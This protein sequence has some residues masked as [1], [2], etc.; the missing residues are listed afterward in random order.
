MEMDLIRFIVSMGEDLLLDS[1]SDSSDISVYYDSEYD[2]EYEY[3]FYNYLNDGEDDSN[4]FNNWYY[5][6]SNDISKGHIAP[7]EVI[8]DALIPLSLNENRIF[9]N[10]FLC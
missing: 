10:I 1:D 8:S 3:A 9:Y 7:A 2:S 5:P 4:Y 6:T